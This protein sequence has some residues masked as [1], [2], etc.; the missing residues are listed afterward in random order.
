MRGQHEQAGAQSLRGAKY[1][2]QQAARARAQRVSPPNEHHR[3][4]RVGSRR[5]RSASGAHRAPEPRRAAQTTL[6]PRLRTARLAD[7]ATPHDA[8]RRSRCAGGVRVHRGREASRPVALPVFDAAVAAQPYSATLTTT[9][10]DVTFQARTDVAPCASYSFRYL[11]EQGFFDGTPCTARVQ[12]R[13]VRHPPVRRPDGDRQ[14]GSRLQVPRREPHRGHVPGRHRRDGEQRR[15]TPT[16]AVLP[17]V[18]R[19]PAESRLHAVRDDH[20]RARRAAAGR[21]RGRR[22]EQSRW[23]RQAGPAHRHHER[24]RSPRP[25]DVA[26][27]LAGWR[28]ASW[29]CRW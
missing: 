3:G 8:V 18:H 27:R 13:V 28:T 14:R 6:L 11:A 10:G 26:P 1:E 16:V 7:P 22:R 2:R 15:R 17:R 25:H 24:R 23:R 12:Q 20:R 21:R 9:Q 19:H 29:C 4:G 5:D